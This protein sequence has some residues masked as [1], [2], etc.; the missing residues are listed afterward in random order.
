[1]H[2]SNSEASIFGRQHEKIREVKMPRFRL[3]GTV[4]AFLVYDIFPDVCINDH[5]CYDRLWSSSA[6]EHKY[7]NIDENF[8]NKIALHAS[9]YWNRGIKT[10]TKITL[11][12]QLTKLTLIL[13]A[14][15]QIY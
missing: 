11:K 14:I 15:F 12:S 4:S 13:S 9:A 1:M 5:V 2:Y 8:M 7:T 10:W 6:K 3:T